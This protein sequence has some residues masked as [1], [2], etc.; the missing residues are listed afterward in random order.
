MSALTVT[1]SVR[2]NAPSALVLVWM[3]A[4]LVPILVWGFAARWSAPA[5]LPQDWGL[6][7]WR[8]ALDSGMYAAL[9]RSA[10]LGLVV[11]A[12]ATPVG[13]MA[14]RA[15]GWREVNY[16]VLVGLVLLAPVVLPPFAV[17]MGLDV[18][19]LRLGIP[20]TLAVVMVLV[21]FAIPYT[22]YTMRASYQS[23]DPEVEEQARVL[24]ATPRQ[25][26]NRASLPAV[27]SGLVAA[28]ALAFLVGWSDYAVTL[29]VGGGRLITMPVL[30]GAT[31]SG[32]GREPA[33]AALSLAAV[34]PPVVA[35]GIV[36]RFA[37]RR[38]SSVST[39]P[40]VSP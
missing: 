27:R 1:R 19:L 22:A 17:S 9:A 38:P 23:V 26:R 40:E 36:L 33:L 3:L 4:P 10:V 32:T 14:G 28:F 29:L 12:I 11:A 34:I 5:V 39:Q 8:Q 30:I 18:L 21:A 16:P 2:R 25:A 37:R 24:G 31:A 20:E 7:G 35:L 15:L 13:A 6:V